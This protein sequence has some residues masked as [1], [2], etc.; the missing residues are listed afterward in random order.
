MLC[1]HNSCKS[2]LGLF[3]FEVLLESKKKNSCR[4]VMLSHFGYFYLK[5]YLFLCVC[6]YYSCIFSCFAG[7]SVCRGNTLNW[8]KALQI[9]FWKVWNKE[10]EYLVICWTSN[11]RID[12][13]R[14]NPKTREKNTRKPKP[15]STGLTA[16]EWSITL[17]SSL[18][19]SIDD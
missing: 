12:Q 8:R 10:T 14:G 11:W 9:M 19:G 16:R 13:N 17:T 15:R 3:S 6:N 2:D 18:T 5:S 1:N 7:F 4:G